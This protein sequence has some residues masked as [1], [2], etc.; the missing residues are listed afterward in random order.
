[1]RCSTD[2]HAKDQNGHHQAMDYATRDAAAGIRRRSGH[3]FGFR[4]A[5]GQGE[6]VSTLPLQAAAQCVDGLQE[7]SPRELQISLT[8]FLERNTKSFVTELWKMLA[9]ASANEF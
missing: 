7:P 8:G 1:M 6:G 2:Q 3:W 9:S 4:H 5:R